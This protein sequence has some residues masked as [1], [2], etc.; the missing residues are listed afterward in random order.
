MWLGECGVGL[1][2]ATTAFTWTAG[3][4]P[5]APDD[6]R[7]GDMLAEEEAYPIGERD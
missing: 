4:R 1:S 6:E 7:N 5:A 3:R 2:F